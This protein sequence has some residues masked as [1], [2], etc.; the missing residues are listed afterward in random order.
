MNIPVVVVIATSRQR[1]S[2]L[3]SRALPSV[4]KQH[5]VNPACIYIVD[6][7][8]CDLEHERIVQGAAQLRASFFAEMFPEGVPDD[9]FPLRVI[10]NERTK[11]HSGSGAWNCGALAAWKV[12]NTG[13][14][15]Y[16]AILDDDDE[17]KK[18]NAYDD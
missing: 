7:N 1:T 3:L 6:D 17:W 8:Q 18:K 2:L 10:R 13:V 16:L 4:F 11:G 15:Q 9:W 5:S 12:R 14:S